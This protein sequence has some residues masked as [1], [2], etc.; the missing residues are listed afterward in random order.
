MPLALELPRAICLNDQLFFLKL[1]HFDENESH[2]DY[3]LQVLAVLD[4]TLQ[5]AN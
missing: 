5:I 2:E 1:E 3:N 4:F